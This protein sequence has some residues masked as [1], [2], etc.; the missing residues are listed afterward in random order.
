M[1]GHVG[2]PL[3]CFWCSILG[4]FLG[5]AHRDCGLHFGHDCQE[6]RSGSKSAETSEMM[7]FEADPLDTFMSNM[8]A[9]AWWLWCPACL[10]CFCLGG[11]LA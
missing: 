10:P 2:T 3:Q 1:L 11:R 4:A 9:D 7:K 8:E 6:F 5:L